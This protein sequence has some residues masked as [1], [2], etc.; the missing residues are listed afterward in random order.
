[1]FN[2]GFE[3][4]D[5]AVVERAHHAGGVQGRGV[6]LVVLDGVGIG[7]EDERGGEER[8]AH[9]GRA[10]HEVV[11]VGIH[12]GYHVIAEGRP[13]TVHQGCLLAFAECAA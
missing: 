3:R 2:E 10:L 13:K 11:V 4:D 9:L 12:A 7:V 6:A 8:A 1:M 5:A